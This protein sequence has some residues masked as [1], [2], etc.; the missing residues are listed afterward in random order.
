MHDEDKAFIKLSFYEGANT[1]SITATTHLPR[2]RNI[3]R[4]LNP[5]HN[6]ESFVSL[7]E[8]RIHC[9]Q[10]RVTQNVKLAVAPRLDA[11]VLHS[12]RY[13]C[14]PEILLLY[15]ELLVADCKRDL[16]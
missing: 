12:A 5:L 3:L 7:V 8:N 2:H 16:G 10:P 1:Q 6:S 13:L 4:T 15:L 14:E 9:L 11:A